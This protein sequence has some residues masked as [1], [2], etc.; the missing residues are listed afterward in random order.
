MKIWPERT[1]W[2]GLW[3]GAFLGLILLGGPQTCR[4]SEEGK[5][6][7]AL[8][9]YLWLAAMDSTVGIGT[10]EAS[11]SMSFGDL[12]ERFNGG[13]MTAI[14]VR[15]G[16]WA[17]LF[18]ILF[19]DLNDDATVGPVAADLTL[20]QFMF[21]FG[22]SRRF[23]VTPDFFVEPLLAGRYMFFRGIIATPT[24][25]VT[26]ARDWLDPVVGVRLGGKKIWKGLSYSVIGDVGGFGAGS[27]FTWDVIAALGYQLGRYFSLNLG[28][29]ALDVDYNSGGV[30]LDLFL[31]GP[32][33]GASLQI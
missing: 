3:V 16:K 11:N 13:F 10:V 4:A 12:I 15:R 2:K 9:P 27:D 21:E 28:Y 1:G 25:T 17:A 30:K 5:V 32:I 26:S 14:E 23:D 20:R 22:G 8:T 31:H 18:N 19:V 7:I 33:I 29:R 24:Q 6:E